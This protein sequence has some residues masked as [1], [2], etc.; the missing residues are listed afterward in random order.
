MYK[1]Q[2]W[3]VMG[4]FPLPLSNEDGPCVQSLQ[5]NQAALPQNP[6]PALLVAQLLMCQGTALQP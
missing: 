5:K 2:P 4:H 6:C 3:A 1:L